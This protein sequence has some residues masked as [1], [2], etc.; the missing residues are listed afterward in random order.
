[1][2]CEIHRYDIRSGEHQCCSF[3]RRS[4][5][6]PCARRAGLSWHCAAASG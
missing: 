5:V 3:R 4:A 2:E 6:L 1:M